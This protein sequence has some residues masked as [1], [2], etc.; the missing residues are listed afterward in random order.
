MNSS[1]GDIED[2]PV[3][4]IRLH[5]FKVLCAWPFCEGAM[6]IGKIFTTLLK[7]V[8]ENWCQFGRNLSKDFGMGWNVG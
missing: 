6:K 8:R 3:A 2:T 7:G 5:T 1:Y 4:E